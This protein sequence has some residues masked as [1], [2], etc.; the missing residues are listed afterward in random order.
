MVCRIPAAIVHTSVLV[1]LFAESVKLG[2]V[3]N[4]KI[5]I[6]QTFPLEQSSAGR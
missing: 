5:K 6:G 1:Y 4:Y 2:K 3:G